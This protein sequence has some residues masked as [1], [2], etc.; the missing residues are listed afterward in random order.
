MIYLLDTNVL[1]DANRDYYPIDRVPEFWDWLLF[2]G[3]NGKI[4]IPYE[5]YREIINGNDNLAVWA[6]KDNVKDAL[7]LD[8]EIDNNLLIQIVHE[9]YGSNLTDIEYDGIGRDAFLIAYAL[10]DNLNRSV[11]TTE[12]SKPSKQKA[13]RHIP[14]ICNQFNIPWHHTFNLTKLLNFS[15]SW[16]N[17]T[18]LI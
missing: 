1:I 15:T 8:E 17:Q 6:K 4:K 5:I 12:A 3:I 2:Y 10:K 16:K 14:D 7:I 11:I 13:N 9:G 18:P